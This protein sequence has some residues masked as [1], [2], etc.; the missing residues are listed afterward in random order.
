MERRLSLWQNG[1]IITLLN[2]GKCIQRHLLPS[3]N[4][5]E[6]LEKTA[7]IFSNLMLQGRVNAAL[8]VISKDTKGGI[9]SMDDLV[10]IGTNNCGHVIEKTTG[11]FLEEK[12]P[13]G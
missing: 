6:N 9:L 11:K 5:A 13:K 3:T 12:H 7:R 2:E 1:D 8:R 10:Q 4:Q